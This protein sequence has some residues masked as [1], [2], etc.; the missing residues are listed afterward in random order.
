LDWYDYGARWYDAAIGRW[1]AVDPL[2]EGY[3]SMSTYNYVSNNP[4]IFIDPDGLFGE[5]YNS[6]GELVHDDGIDDDKV[7]FVNDEDVQLVEDISFPSMYEAVGQYIG[8]KNEFGLIQLT[9]MG[10]SNIINNENAEDTYSY[11]DSEGNTVAAGK[12]GDDWVTPET[13]AA[14]LGAVND[15]VE[16]WGGLIEVVVNDGSAYNPKKNLG[17]ASRGDHSRGEGA[18]LRFL[19]IRSGG[20]NNIDNLTWSG[21]VMSESFVEKLRNHGF[22]RNFVDKGKIKGT[23]HAKGHKDHIHT[24]RSN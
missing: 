2:A 19:T 1:N 15:M 13:A 6:Q 23:T 10:S 24:G 22:D 14:F 9:E 3:Y 7:Y 17:H 8:T 5:Y 4:I 20:G 21:K 11:I 18:D 12:H 16:E